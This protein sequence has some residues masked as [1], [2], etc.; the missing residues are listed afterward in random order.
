MLNM[1]LNIQ[2]RF[3]PLH[4]YCRLVEKGLNKRCSL[5]ICGYYE[6]FVYGWLAWLT[7]VGVQI[8]RLTQRKIITKILLVFL[9]A[10]ILVLG[11][12]GIAKAIPTDF[13][14]I[15]YRAATEPVT[16]FLFGCSLVGLS[17]LMRKFTK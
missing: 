5:S 6:I 4:V 16:L 3:N 2:H 7:R 9:C 13:I 17:G 8:C 12:A 15:W 14:E 10:V 1:M 11:V